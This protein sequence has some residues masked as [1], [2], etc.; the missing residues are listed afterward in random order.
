MSR[1]PSLGLSGGKPSATTTLLPG[2]KA[3]GLSGVPTSETTT[4]TSADL[5]T[6]FP[7]SLVLRKCAILPPNSRLGLSGVP[8]A[9]AACCRLIDDQLRPTVFTHPVN[10]RRW[11][12][13]DTPVQIANAFHQAATSENPMPPP[14]PINPNDAWATGATR[15]ANLP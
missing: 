10:R 2:P 14:A 12:V 13:K 7:T 9:N 4:S 8:T 1:N 15:R 3:C 6:R 11:N 5:R